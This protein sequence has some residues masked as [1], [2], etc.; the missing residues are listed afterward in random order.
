MLIRRGVEADRD[1]ISRFNCELALET[2]QCVLDP[3]IVSR[4]VSRALA[5]T[6]GADYWLAE[7]DN[8]VIGQLMTTR[9]WSDWRDGWYVWLQS[10]YV[11]PTS[12]G[13]GVFRSLLTHVYQNAAETG[14][15]YSIRLYVENENQ[16]ASETYARL[17]FA[18]S[19]YRVLERTVGNS[20]GKL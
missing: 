15:V 4:G 12:R 17:G 20:R 13:R 2:E 9:E 6:R 10:V 3:A 18:E 11:T 5:E 14:D 8:R 16:T 19:G 7:V 1:V